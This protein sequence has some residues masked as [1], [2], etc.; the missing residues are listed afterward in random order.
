MDNSEKVNKYLLGDNGVVYQ[1]RLGEGI[2]AA[3][4]DGFGE[5]DS[6]G[7]FDSETAPNQDFSISKDE[8]A[9]TELQKLIKENS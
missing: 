4:M 3:P 2:P 6:N 8:A 7:D 9:Q 5:L 1:L